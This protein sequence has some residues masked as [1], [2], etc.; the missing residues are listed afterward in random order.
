MPDDSLRFDWVS[1]RP[2]NGHVLDVK[3][4]TS[5]CKCLCKLFFDKCQKSVKIQAITN[6]DLCNVI[7]TK[8]IYYHVAIKEEYLQVNCVV[9]ENN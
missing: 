4:L 5:G 3:L 2:W 9:I 1:R 7:T 8:C 6:Y